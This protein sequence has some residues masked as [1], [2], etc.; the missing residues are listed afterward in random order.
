MKDRLEQVCKLETTS[1][2]IQV[3]NAKALDPKCFKCTQDDSIKSS[4][5]ELQIDHGE[6]MVV[7]RNQCNKIR[8]GIQNTFRI[9]FGSDVHSTAQFNVEYQKWQNIKTLPADDV[10]EIKRRLGVWED[11]HRDYQA[12]FTLQ[13][14][15]LVA[16]AEFYQEKVNLAESNYLDNSKDFRKNIGLLQ[17]VNNALGSIRLDMDF[18]VI[19]LI[20]AYKIW[21]AKW[22]WCLI[23]L[24][25]P[26]PI[27]FTAPVPVPVPAQPKEATTRSLPPSHYTS[28]RITRVPSPSS[29]QRKP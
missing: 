25:Q 21:R 17:R 1:E 22:M 6:R 14:N 23:N 20:E 3:F 12:E 15:L 2:N 26:I 8:V 29:T 24:N 4:I 28:T 27:H 10:T 7:Y 5:S 9:C 13:L 19:T 11:Q 18:K 16:R